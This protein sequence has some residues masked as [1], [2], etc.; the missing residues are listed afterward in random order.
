[1]EIARGEYLAFVDSDDHIE[2]DMCRVLYEAAAGADM[3]GADYY[4]DDQSLY[5]A[6]MPFGFERRVSGR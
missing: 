1:M 5:P 2:P 6:N 4:I 3:C